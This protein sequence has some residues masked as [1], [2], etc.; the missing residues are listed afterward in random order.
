MKFTASSGGATTLTFANNSL[1]TA[2][3]NS[4]RTLTNNAANLSIVFAGALA[5]PSTN[6]AGGVAFGGD[7]NFTVNGAI[8]T[9]GGS[10]TD[11]SVTKNGSGTL[12]L[13][14]DNDYQGVTNVNDGTVIITGDNTLAIGD[15]TV[16]SGA[17]LGGNGTFGGNVTIASGAT[18]SLAVAATSAAQDTSAITGTLA[19]A[20]SILNLTAT[21]TP[22][23]GVYVL[24]TATV[25]IT[26]TP[27]TI[28]TNGIS[29]TVSVDTASSPK[30]LLLTVS[31]DSPFETWAGPGV[32]FDAD[33][34]N[35]GVDN[36]MAWVLGAANASANALP[37]L[38]TMDNT[39]DP[40]FFIFTYRRDDDANTNPNT[41]IKVE[42]GSILSG[43]TAAVASANVIITPTDDFYAPGIDRVQVKIRRT[44]AVGGKLF[45]RLN[46]VNTP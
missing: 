36:G 38:P 9:I 10:F 13:N 18:H 30:R 34:N 15:V 8:N 26:G 3:G 25:G 17:T 31:V 11:R 27:A 33:A 44:L 23:P 43:W 20:G 42:Y 22:D 41:A 19:M 24:A 2:G 37:L 40:D 1:A 7:G 5:I 32:A 21:S 39:S 45:A 14:G 35:D 46:V 6:S 4:G 28:N 29:G 16:A 12:T